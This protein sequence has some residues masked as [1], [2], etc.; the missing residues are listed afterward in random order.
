M[1]RLMEWKSPKIQQCRPWHRAMAR[2]VVA[3]ARPMEIAE[4]FGYTAG[5]ISKIIQSPL[6]EAELHRLESEAEAAA[7]D[8]HEDLA[9]M[10]LRAAEILDREL[11]PDPTDLRSRE[12][13]VQV[14]FGV[15]DRAGF[16]KRDQPV[17]HLHKHQH[18]EVKNLTNEELLKNVIDL[19]ADEER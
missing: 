2:M 9:Q 10:S 14:A 18:L 7:V 19:T 4:S 5:Q 12:H 6:F 3:G 11:Q 16:T 13:Q 8:I 1:G 17:M 15:L